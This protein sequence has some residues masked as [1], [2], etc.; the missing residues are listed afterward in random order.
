MRFGE[1]K[2]FLRGVTFVVRMAWHPGLKPIGAKKSAGTQ[3][4][5]RERDDLDTHVEHL[6]LGIGEPR[7]NPERRVR[8]AQR[9]I[10]HSQHINVSDEAIADSR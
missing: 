6:V 10:A 5:N 7:K 8:V 9:D 1:K 3:E 2:S 4:R